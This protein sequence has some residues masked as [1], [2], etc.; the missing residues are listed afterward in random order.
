MIFQTWFDK[1]V[2]VEFGETD[3][4]PPLSHEAHFTWTLSERAMID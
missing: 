1:L 3:L 4:D 2:H